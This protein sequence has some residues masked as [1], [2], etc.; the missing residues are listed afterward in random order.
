MDFEKTWWISLASDKDPADQWATNCKLFSLAE[1]CAL[2]SAVVVRKL[3]SLKKVRGYKNKP[4][5]FKL[6]ANRNVLF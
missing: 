4:S 6:M 5:T 2:P 3:I 1:G